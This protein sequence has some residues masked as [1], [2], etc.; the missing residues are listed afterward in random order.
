MH[1]PDWQGAVPADVPQVIAAPGDDVWRIGRILV[2][3]SAGDIDAVRALQAQ[4]RVIRLD[5]SDAA[6]RFDTR[7]DGRAVA[8]PSAALYLAEL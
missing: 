6:Q 1:G 8:T 2:D 7:I 5:H 4:L 3:D